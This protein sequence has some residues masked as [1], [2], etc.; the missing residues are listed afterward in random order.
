MD[1]TCFNH[2]QTQPYLSKEAV[3]YRLQFNTIKIAFE[4]VFKW[5]EETVSVP[6]SSL[7]SSCI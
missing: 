4:D 3:R 2:H 5:I 7:I 6:L 1:G